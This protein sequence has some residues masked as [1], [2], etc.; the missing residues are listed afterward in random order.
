MCVCVCVCMC[1]H[2][3]VCVLECK[4]TKNPQVQRPH[5]LLALSGRLPEVDLA[6]MCVCVFIRA[7]K[8]VHAIH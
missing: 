4:E 5:R 1:V 8:R 6:V 7:G 2:V 3:C